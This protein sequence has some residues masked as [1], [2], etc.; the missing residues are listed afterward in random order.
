MPFVFCL[1]ISL[2]APTSPDFRYIRPTKPKPICKPI[3]LPCPSVLVHVWVWVSRSHSLCP[4]SSCSSFILRGTM[5]SFGCHMAAKRLIRQRRT[6]VLL[7]RLSS[8]TVLDTLKLAIT[9]ILIFFTH[10][11]L[12]IEGEWKH[13]WRIRRRG[14]SAGRVHMASP[15][16]GNGFNFGCSDDYTRTNIIQCKM[17][18]YFHCHLKESPSNKNRACLLWFSLE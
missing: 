11:V 15:L 4:E 3:H 18:Q 8:I 14:Y 12:D 10:F 5:F 1:G 7:W 2:R 9:P 16:P 6:Y 13:F 17:D